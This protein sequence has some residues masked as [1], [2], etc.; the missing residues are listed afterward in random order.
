M[1]I[2]VE[3]DVSQTWLATKKLIF[4]HEI[5]SDESRFEEVFGSLL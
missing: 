3:D 2:A 1:D 4:V 5:P